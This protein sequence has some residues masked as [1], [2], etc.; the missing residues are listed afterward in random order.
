MRLL[1]L[2]GLFRGGDHETLALAPVLSSLNGFPI[3]RFVAT[4][5]LCLHRRRHATASIRPNGEVEC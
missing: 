4:V 5:F 1:F 3:P 2:V